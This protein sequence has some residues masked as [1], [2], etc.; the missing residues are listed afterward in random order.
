MVW[1]TPKTKKKNHLYFSRLNLEKNV[2]NREMISKIVEHRNNEQ[3]EPV[4]VIQERWLRKDGKRPSIFINE[5][6]N[7]IPALISG[8]SIVTL[9]PKQCD[10][11]NL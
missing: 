1:R 7:R 10:N 8:T 5:S 3:Q 4:S 6:K 2:F 9:I 11:L